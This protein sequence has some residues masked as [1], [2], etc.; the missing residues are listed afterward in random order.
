MMLAGRLFVL[1][2][3]TLAFAGCGGGDQGDGGAAD[4]N[5]VQVTITGNDQMKFDKKVIEVPAGATITLTLKHVGKMPLETMGHNWVL[6][7]QGTDLDAF[8]RASASAKDTDYIPA[9]RKDQVIVHTRML[10]GGESDTITFTAPAKGSYKFICSFPGH[11]LAM[12]GFF[13]VR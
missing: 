2:F 12:Q 10:G 8:A 4:A 7:A 6:L 9:R 13:I 5:T 3:A 1:F 11:Y